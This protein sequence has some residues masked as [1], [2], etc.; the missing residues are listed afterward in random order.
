MTS[1]LPNLIASSRVVL[2]FFSWWFRISTLS[3]LW[4]NDFFSHAVACV[5]G[6]IIN[7]VLT[8]FKIMIA[9]S[10]ERSSAGKPSFLKVRS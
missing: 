3:L 8:E 9:F 2:N 10:M 1:T 5:A 7:G 4:I 6:S